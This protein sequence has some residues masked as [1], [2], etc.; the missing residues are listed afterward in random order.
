MSLPELTVE[1]VIELVKQLPPE[2]KKLVL[3]VLQSE[4]IV[5]DP[6]MQECLAHEIPQRK[7]DKLKRSTDT[8]TQEWLDAD[9][10]GEIPSYEWG[11]TGVPSGKPIKYIS[12]QGFVVE[13]GK[14][15]VECP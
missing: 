2:G 10:S 9:L 3:A 11:E 14:D 7:A 4:F 12:G 1:Q 5:T 6:K 15:F 13:E 8:E